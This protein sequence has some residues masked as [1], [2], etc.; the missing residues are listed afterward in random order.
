MPS[1]LDEMVTP[2]LQVTRLLLDGLMEGILT[3]EVVKQFE[4]EEK[5]DRGLLERL[6]LL[7]IGTE[8]LFRAFRVDSHEIIKKVNGLYEALKKARSDD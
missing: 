1:S 4:K 5:L 8:S 7:S 2:L 3:E 6:L